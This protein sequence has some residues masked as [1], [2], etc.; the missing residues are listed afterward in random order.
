MFAAIF[1]G[2][3]ALVGPIKFLI[4]TASSWAGNMVEL[5][6]LKHDAKVAQITAQAELAAYKYKA[7]LE[8]D[9][10]WAGQASGT[11]KD[12]YLLVL[13]S[14]PIIAFLP[15]LIPGP[16]GD[17]FMAHSMAVLTTI[18]KVDPDIP[19]WFLG[20]WSIMFAAVFGN[21]AASQIMMGSKIK[22]IA[23]AFQPLPDDVPEE[24]VKA[25]TDRIKERLAKTLANRKAAIE[26]L[27]E[28]GR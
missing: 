14:L 24:A 2:L 13:F 12:E 26:P 23:E 15:S 9:L 11:W 8:W 25:A 19:T 27:K 21:K 7:D 4:K 10:A 3:L 20:A 5:Q 6:A 1:A 28:S 22:Q 18:S 17:L 16:I